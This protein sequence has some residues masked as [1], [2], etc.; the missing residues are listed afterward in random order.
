MKKTLLLLLIGALF[1]NV[2]AQNYDSF[3]HWSVAIHGGLSQFDGDVSQT[4]PLI[5]GADILPT[6]GISVENTITSVHGFGFELLYSQYGGTDSS[7]N[8][9]HFL[10]N[11]Y[12]GSF[13]W[14][15]NVANWIFKNRKSN[16]NIYAHLGA[17]LASYDTKVE[18]IGFPSNSVWPYGKTPEQ[19]SINPGD[20]W[21][22]FFPMGASVEYNL[23][24]ALALGIRI[25]YRSF[26]KDN[27][28][29]KYRQNGA[30]GGA[31]FNYGGVT[32]DYLAVATLNLRY[33]F[34][35]YQKCHTKN[36][37]LEEFESTT[38]KDLQKKLAAADSALAKNQK[39]LAD[40]KGK[41]NDLEPRLK[42]LEGLLLKDTDGDGVPDYLDICPN[43]P[44]S[45]KV[46][47]NGCPKDTDMDGIGDFEDKCPD[48]YGKKENKGC[49]D[50]AES[51]KKVFERALKGIFFETDKD[52]IKPVSFPI[53][54]N[55]VSIMKD[56]PAYKLLI[57]GHTD[58]DNT[59]E[60][61]QNLSERRAEAVKQY[62]IS[63]GVEANRLTPQGF[64]ES[65][66]IATNNT[67]TGKALNRRV[68]FVVVF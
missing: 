1:V 20:G 42:D 4:S 38:G 29:G 7:P 51:T 68:E 49:P 3:S 25:D 18:R 12:Q 34:G 31:D 30:W 41:L 60:Y 56:N 2:N 5:P 37:C 44:K 15:I 66:P 53:L 21:A 33:K 67:V 39:D 43:T 6:F 58:S 16:W 46:N 28:D 9:Y 55:V 48:V 54:D 36:N 17:G 64:G 35:A 63:H 52:I 23:S 50:V 57:N 26:N 11:A 40:A 10:G 24:K 62:L 59:D 22:L 14:A 27:L 13:Y 61:N 65:R 32:N 47:E 45:E 8:D 19:E